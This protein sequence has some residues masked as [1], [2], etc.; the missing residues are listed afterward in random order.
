ME[1]KNEI[2]KYLAKKNIRKQMEKGKKLLLV[3]PV[4]NEENIIE[5][6]LTE[7]Y[8][9]LTNLGF[10]FLLAIVVD[11]SG[12]RSVDICRTFAN[13]HANVSLIVHEEKLGRGLAV[14]EAWEKFTGDYYAFIDADLSTGLEIIQIALEKM[15]RGDVDLI[16][17]SRYVNGASARRPP[18]RKKVSKLY[19]LGL[20]LIFKENIQDHQCGFKLLKKE[21]KEKILHNTKINSWFWDTE[22]LIISNALGFKILEIP[23]N[24]KEEKYKNT[25]LMRLVKD[26]YLHGTGIIRLK[27]EIENI[28]KS[29]TV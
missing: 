2:V 29:E 8:E 3:V 12:D 6:K 25:S 15:E 16:T 21:S 13:R 17:A 11:F 22:L 27:G 10:Q 4:Y 26:I 1:P 5:N 14:R 20:R 23:V 19:N 28:R 9:Y 18:L 24:W 7:L